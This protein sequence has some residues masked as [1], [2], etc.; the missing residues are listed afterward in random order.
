MSGRKPHDQDIKQAA[1]SQITKLLQSTAGKSAAYQRPVFGAL[2]NV[3]EPDTLRLMAHIP[4]HP[5]AEV[6]EAAAIVFRRMP[7][8]ATADFAARW[9]AKETDAN[10]KRKLWHTI[11][12]Q[13]FDAREMTSRKVLTYAVRDLRQKP[14]PITRKSLIR[15]LARAK[16]EMPNDKLGIEDAF[17]E[18]LPYEFEQK[19]GLHRLMEEHIDPERR[20]AIYLEV[21]QSLESNG[22]TAPGGVPLP[23]VP[24]IGGETAQ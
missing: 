10:V 23:E 4:D 22:A 5:D 24:A 7:P 14:G 18:L 13:T 6:R 12:L 9:L 21:S 17:A 1:I 19:S 2:A 15:L 3:G 16:Q 8:A 20:D 11:E